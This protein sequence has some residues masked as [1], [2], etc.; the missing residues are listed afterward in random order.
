MNVLEML[1]PRYLGQAVDD[2][3]SGQFTTSSIV[4]YV[5]IF[6]CLLGVVVYT[7]TYFWMYQLFGGAKCHGA[8]DARETDAPLA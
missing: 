4:F 3:R 8:C 7:L 2:I 5:T 6:F 1:P